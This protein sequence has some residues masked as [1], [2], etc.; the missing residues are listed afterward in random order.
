M[1]I[2]RLIFN[3]EAKFSLL[4][5]NF[6][7]FI[8][9]FEKR[10]GKLEFSKSLDGTSKFSPIHQKVWKLRFLFPCLYIF[11]NGEDGLAVRNYVKLDREEE[12]IIYD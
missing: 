4:G 9:R 1:W 3:S 12:P 10:D 11:S 8:H 2:L 5:N 6:S 7:Q